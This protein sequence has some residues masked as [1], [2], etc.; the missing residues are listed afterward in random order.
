MKWFLS[1]HTVSE[2]LSKWEDSP[3]SLLLNVGAAPKPAGPAARADDIERGQM[4]C[5]LE[6]VRGDTHTDSHT[7]TRKLLHSFLHSF[8]VM[9]GFCASRPRTDSG[10]NL[11]FRE[12]GVCGVSYPT[13]KIFHKSPTEPQSALPFDASWFPEPYK[14]FGDLGEGNSPMFECV[15]FGMCSAANDCNCLTFNIT[16]IRITESNV[17]KSC[18]VSFLC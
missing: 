18:P 13:F 9:K 6:K 2:R 14:R 1:S 10:A 17:S 11:L 15:E 7:H 16:Q 12:E 8:P 4:M 3:R 5:N